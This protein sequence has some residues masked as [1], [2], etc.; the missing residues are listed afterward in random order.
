MSK[1]E[2]DKKINLA[3]VDMRY[4]VNYLVYKHRFPKSA[5]TVYCER[6]KK[7]IHSD[8]FIEPMT[9]GRWRHV[10]YGGV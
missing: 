8:N 4:Y 5:I 10:L 7:V 3:K 1:E 9:Y 6:R 2:I